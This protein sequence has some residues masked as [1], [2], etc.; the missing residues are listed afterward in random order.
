MFLVGSWVKEPKIKRGHFYQAWSDAM[1]SRM[2]GAAER[3]V[4]LTDDYQ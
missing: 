1:T 4:G 3:A 2:V